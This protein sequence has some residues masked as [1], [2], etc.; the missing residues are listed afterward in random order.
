M[1]QEQ[2]QQQQ[3]QQQQTQKCRS[4]RFCPLQAAFDAT[5]FSEKTVIQQRAHKPCWLCGHRHPMVWRF[6]Q[7]REVLKDKLSRH[8]V[9][10]S[11]LAVCNKIYNGI[12][13]KM[14]HSMAKYRKL[15]PDYGVEW[16]SYN[17]NVEFAKCWFNHYQTNVQLMIIGS[18]SNPRDTGYEHLGTL[19][20]WNKGDKSSYFDNDNKSRYIH[21]QITSII[22]YLGYNTNNVSW[23]YYGLNKKPGFKD[24]CLSLNVELMLSISDHIK[25]NKEQ[26]ISEKNI[27][28]LIDGF[29]RELF[30]K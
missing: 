8:L 5:T 23:H 3:Q 17:A 25:S 11:S 10:N 14:I 7:Y 2:K 1:A 27:C 19:V 29:H 30:R 12:C 28:D 18:Y 6:M 4:L 16:G 21:Q 13:H 20:H 9:W 15:S 22:K 24:I 26:W